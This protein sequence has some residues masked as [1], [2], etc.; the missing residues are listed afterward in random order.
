MGGA[1][2][3]E[4]Q[5]GVGSTFSV[6]LPARMSGHELQADILEPGS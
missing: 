6:R 5:L 2:A 4:S 1:I 3:V